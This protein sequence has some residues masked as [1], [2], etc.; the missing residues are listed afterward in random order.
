MCNDLEGLQVYF[1]QHYKMNEKQVE[2]MI[3]NKVFYR[4]EGG[5]YEFKEE[6]RHGRPYYTFNRP[7]SQVVENVSWSADTLTKSDL[8]FLRKYGIGSKKIEVPKDCRVDII[9]SKDLNVVFDTTWS[10]RET[11]RLKYC[12]SNPFGI[13]EMK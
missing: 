11:S 7:A 6:E 4:P 9:A 12:I 8:I 1:K 13:L 3:K 5:L 10:R 2:K